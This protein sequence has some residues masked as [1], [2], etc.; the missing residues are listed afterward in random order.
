MKGDRA[1]SADVGTRKGRPG[2]CSKGETETDFKICQSTLL[3]MQ[4]VEELNLVIITDLNLI[5]LIRIRL[6]D[7]SYGCEV[8]FST[9]L[10]VLSELL[11]GESSKLE[12]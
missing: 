8:H 5:A 3:H 12:D 11:P 1:V 2:E 4:R 6:L 10:K 9:W 7:E